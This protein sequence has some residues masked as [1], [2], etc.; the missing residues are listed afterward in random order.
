MPLLGRRSSWRRT[1]LRISWTS[2]WVGMGTGVDMH[3]DIGIPSAELSKG[4]S[5]P[6]FGQPSHLWLL[7]SPSG[8][9]IDLVCD[10]S[11]GSSLLLKPKRIEEIARSMSRSMSIPLTLKTRKGYYDGNDVSPLRKDSDAAP[12]K[13]SNLSILPV[14][15]SSPYFQS[16]LPGSARHSTH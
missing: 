3:V 16:K 8:C 6:R 10:K 12:E 11:A 5:Y 7:S 2:I 9:P 13:A 4:L 1:S 15:T 14:H